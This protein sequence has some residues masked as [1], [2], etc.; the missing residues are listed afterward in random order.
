MKYASGVVLA[1]AV[2]GLTVGACGSD[3]AGTA[4]TGGASGVAGETGAGG[5]SEAGTDGSAAAGASASDAGGTGGDETG[6]APGGAGETGSGGS[7]GVA[8]SEASG[9]SSGVA[10]SDGSGGSSGVAGSDGLGGSAPGVCVPGRSVACVG[11][12]GCDG[13]QVCNA[14][15]TGYDACDCGSLCQPGTVVACIGPAGCDGTQPCSSEGVP[16]G[17]C[18]CL[19]PTIDCGANVWDGTPDGFDASIT[20]I[21]GSVTITLNAQANSYGNVRCIDGSLTISC[22]NCRTGLG[23]A[24]GALQRVGALNIVSNHGLPAVPWFPALVEVANLTIAD[25]VHDGTYS[26]FDSLTG[27]DNLRFVTGN[28]TIHHN[29]GLTTVDGLEGLL[30]IGGALN[31]YDQGSLNDLRG[32]SGLRLVGSTLTISG[33]SDLANL[34]GME[35]LTSIGGGLILWDHDDLTETSG[36][37]NLQTIGGELSIQRNIVLAQLTLGSLSLLGGNL[38][39]RDNPLLPTC[40]ATNLA[41]LLQAGGWTGNSTIDGNGDGTCPKESRRLSKA[42]PRL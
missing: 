36:L 25:N 8:G 18:T 4:V 11:P 15:G 27:L 23:S 13:A 29:L 42:A 37:E 28:L 6:G 1:V 2:A 26:S 22:T 32:L 3:G 33:P 34:Q 41:D 31:I 21:T 10:G 5:S 39:V 12:G 14:E 24:F 9:G 16:S 30:E 38:V 17:T 19:P 35:S 20:H 7:S 40:Q